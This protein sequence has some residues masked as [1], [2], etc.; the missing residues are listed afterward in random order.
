MKASVSDNGCYDQNVGKDNNETHRHA[1]TDNHIVTV[2]PVRTDFFFTKVIEKFDRFIV[3]ALR[4]VI[5]NHLELS[6]GGTGEERLGSDR[7]F[8]QFGWEV[9]GWN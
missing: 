1:H 8:R 3:V 2:T 4:C 5:G 7:P 9:V 6:D